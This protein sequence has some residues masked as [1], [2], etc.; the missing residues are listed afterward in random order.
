[1]KYI[2]GIILAFLFQAQVIAQ[3]ADLLNDTLNTTLNNKFNQYNLQGVT[4]AVA[5]PDGSVWTNTAGHKG[6]VA[7]NP[8]VLFEAGSISKSTIAAAILLLEEAGKLSIDDTLYHYLSP[9]QNVSFGITLKQ[10]LNHTNGLY[11]YTSHP[12]FLSFVNDP[13]NWNTLVSIDSALAQWVDPPL[14]D[15]GLSWSYCNTGFLL[16]GKVVEAVENKALNLVLD[17]LLFT[18]LSLDNTFLAGYDSYPNDHSGY[19]LDAGVFEPDPAMSFVSAAWA[20]GG[21]FMTSSDLAK[22]GNELFSGN[23]ISVASFTK[24]TDFVDDGY[25][26][27]GLAINRRYYRTREYLGHTGATLMQAKLSHSVEFDFS[28]AVISSDFGSFNSTRFIE[29]ALID[30][31]NFHMDN[32]LV[33]EKNSE[34][35]DVRLFPNPSE[36]QITLQNLYDFDALMVFDTKGAQKLARKLTTPQCQLQKS[37]LGAGVFIL[38]LIQNNGDVVHKRIIFR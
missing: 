37:E 4:A 19:W 6:T 7:L 3:Y 31:V 22:W 25:D 1:M 38:K 32:Y 21:L 18:P 5:F 27:Y 24:L 2:Y 36:N 20:A 10:L 35:A 13:A 15:P 26:G 29:N 30:A 33:I 16:L 9:L 14:K 34:K 11:N 8:D 12:D 23:I 28:V 17:S